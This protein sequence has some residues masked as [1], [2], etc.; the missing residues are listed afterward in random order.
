MK[1]ED[2]SLIEEFLRRTLSEKEHNAFLERLQNDPEFRQAY[3]FEK[4]LFENLDDSQ[5]NYIENK[6]AQPVKAYKA[7]FESEK[8]QEL[9]QTLTEIGNEYVD[10]PKAKKKWI[11]YAVAAVI[12]ILIT[13]PF[14]FTSNRVDPGQLYTTYFEASQLPS[15]AS[16]GDSPDSLLIRAQGYFDQKDY[17]N[18][19]VLYSEAS[20]AQ[21][22][23]SIVQLAKGIS[24]MELGLF[25]EAEE[26][27]IAFAK[28]EFMDAS[29]G[30]W[31]LALLY[32]KMEETPKAESI[33]N[34]IIL[35]E[36]YNYKKAEEILEKL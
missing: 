17:E 23:K 29:K 3:E 27:L 21:Q 2:L 11:W 7:L 31:F 1:Q 15:L 10:Q 14:L 33:L 16:R 28:S 24:E 20:P 12:A 5:W 22:N 30:E 9:T 25:Q 34:K 32:L 8:T 6:S 35:E 18:V 19:L 36:S 13:T 26:T 4:Q